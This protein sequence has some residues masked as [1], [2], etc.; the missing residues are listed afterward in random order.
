MRSE[1]DALHIVER[2]ETMLHALVILCVTVITG[3]FPPVAASG[4]YL[5]FQAGYMPDDDFFE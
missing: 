2:S 5:Y 3:I 1:C 4:V